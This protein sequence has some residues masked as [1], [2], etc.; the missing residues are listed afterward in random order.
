MKKHTILIILSLVAEIAVAQKHTISGVVRDASS[1]E[2]LPAANVYLS[3]GVGTVT[4]NYGFFAI[5]TN[6]TSVTL[7]A[8]YVGYSAY[9]QTFTIT[10]DTVVDIGILS[11]NQIEEV[12]VT[13]NSSQSRL[14]SSQFN[15]ANITMKEVAQLPTLLGEHDVLKA[16]QTMPGIGSGADGMTGI[17]VRGG[18]PDQNLILLDGAPVYNV[19]HLFG[20]LS[21]FNAEAIKSVTVLKGGFPARYG[22][23][24][25]S[26]L[27]IQMKEGNVNETHGMASVGLLSS[28]LAIEGPIDE[29]TSYLLALRR[30]Y[31]DLIMWPMCKMSDIRDGVGKTS[32]GYHFTDINAKINHRIDAKSQ[33]FASFYSGIDKFRSH[34]E[35]PGGGY[36]VNDKFRLK[37]QNQTATM[38]YNRTLGNKLFMNSS[39]IYSRYKYY[40]KSSVRYDYFNSNRYE[41]SSAMGESAL[42]DWTAKADFDWYPAEKHI[43]KTGLGITRHSFSPEQSAYESGYSNLVSTVADT[44]YGTKKVKSTDLSTYIEDDWTIAKSLKANMGVRLTLFNVEGRT[45]T[46]VEPRAS[47][48]YLINDN[49]SVKAAYSKMTQYVHL[50]SNSSVGLPTDQWL[51]STRR[52]KPETSDQISVGM[53]YNTPDY[54]FT[55]EGFY[56]KMNNLIE[57]REGANYMSYQNWE[58]KLTSG[59]GRAYGLE[60]MAKRSVGSTTGW[61]SYTLL[62]S[63][64]KFAELNNGERFPFKYD[65]RHDISIVAMHTFS[66]KF[67][68]SANWNVSSGCRVTLPVARFIDLDGEES[69]AYSKRNEY[70]MPLYHRLDVSANLNRPKRRGMAT[71]TFGVYNLYARQNP[72]YI[73][74]DSDKKD[75]IDEPRYFLKKVSMF[76]I[77][78]TISYTFRF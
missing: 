54:E 19:N 52:I 56:K 35:F 40:T 24:L 48:C 37:W 62:W 38:R 31:Y 71:W 23:R 46:S 58:E 69:V 51:P 43:V 20:F 8:S 63:N 21:V 14:R 33:L 75:W 61:V 6:H 70:R 26:V 50:V 60:F 34:D 32:A 64:R 15:I 47:F 53:Q 77:V 41:Y 65:R 59:S 11:D 25:S 67:N 7:N 3:T 16:M 5:T 44:S 10:K 39:L 28:Q 27:D 2:L 78:P 9:S 22:G 57:F 55:V 66:K 49:L 12:V 30:A 72:L 13:D 68:V 18:S 29:K 1:G 42:Q 76:T 4:N 74:A 17:Y 73:Y 36:D 45:Y